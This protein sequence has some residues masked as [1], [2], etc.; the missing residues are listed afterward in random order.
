MTLLLLIMLAQYQPNDP[1]HYQQNL[2]QWE[3]Q[4]EQFRFEQRWQDQLR[5]QDE[6]QERRQ[7]LNDERQGSD[8]D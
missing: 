7:Q 4:Q 2:R 3:Q 6:W 5:R 1:Y 8:D